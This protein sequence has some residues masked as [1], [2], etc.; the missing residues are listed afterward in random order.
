[1]KEL[2]EEEKINFTKKHGGIVIK[3]TVKVAEKDAGGIVIDLTKS[4][5]K[6][7]VS[8]SISIKGPIKFMV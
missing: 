4:N 3:E 2:K 6:A 1:M 8:G 7:E 5:I